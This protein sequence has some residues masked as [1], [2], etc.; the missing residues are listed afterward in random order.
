MGVENGSCGFCA[1]YGGLCFGRDRH[2]GSN[3]WQL[4]S[5]ASDGAKSI[6]G[7]YDRGDGVE[8]STDGT[9]EPTGCERRHRGV[10]RNDARC[11]SGW[12]IDGVCA[13]DG[14]MVAGVVIC[15]DNRI[16]YS[17]LCVKFY[18]IRYSCP[19]FEIFYLHKYCCAA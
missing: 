6:C 2:V 10:G 3:L 9:Q 16:V 14:D 11:G 1:G 17:E 7:V 8:W 15:L 5:T 12:S 18:F 4:P 19:L 13:G